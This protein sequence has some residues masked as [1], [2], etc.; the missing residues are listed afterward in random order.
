MIIWAVVLVSAVVIIVVIVRLT[1]GSIS[2]ATSAAC[3]VNSLE[4][5]ENTDSDELRIGALTRHRC[6]YD[7]ASPYLFRY[8]CGVCVKR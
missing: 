4:Q 6:F 2:F 5:A 8:T 1:I 7:D 3:S